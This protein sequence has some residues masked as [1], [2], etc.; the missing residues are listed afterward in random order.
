[1]RILFHHRTQGQGVE[2]VHIMGMVNAFLQ[3]G[4]Q[5]EIVSPPG[6]T[7][8]SV[9][10]RCNVPL[11]PAQKTETPSRWKTII[12]FFPGVLFELM[13]LFYNLI[14]FRQLKKQV[15]TQPFDMIYERYAFFHFAGAWIAKQGIP[16]FLEINFTCD[17]PLY[18]KRSFFIRP[19]QKKI[20]EMIF[21]RADGLIVVSQGL[22]EQ[23]IKKGIAPDKIVVTPNAVDETFLVETHSGETIR[24]QLQLVGKKVVGFVGGFYPWHGL[25]LLIAV[26]P[27]IA[28]KVPHVALLLIGDGPLQKV[29]K[30]EVHRIGMDGFVVFTGQ[31]P[32]EALPQYIAAFDLGVMP[33]SNDYGSPMKIYEYMAMGKPVVAPKLPPLEEGIIDD[34]TGLLFPPKDRKGLA[35]AIVTLL[36]DQGR[37]RAMGEAARQHVKRNHT[38]KRNAEIVLD[39]LQKTKRAE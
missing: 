38:W 26:L 3:A 25:D 7:V 31:I 11:H 24:Q 23:L 9:G 22:K 34:E 13:E 21:A 15:E 39:L 29:I 36:C 19:I 37:C 12:R 1:M 2:R 6:V 5:V 16:F 14:S 10:A 17:T 27:D 28:R 8:S 18:R 20:E 4:H 30:E 35:A 32:H 33:D